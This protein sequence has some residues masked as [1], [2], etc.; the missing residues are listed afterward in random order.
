MC[1]IE[2]RVDEVWNPAYTAFSQ[3]SAAWLD[4]LTI[5]RT[6]SACWNNATNA[7]GELSAFWLK[8]I[9]LIYPFPFT[10][11]DVNVLLNWLNGNFPIRNG[12]CFNYIVGQEAI[13]CSPEYGV[14]NR[15]VSDS[16]GAGNQTV[17]FSWTCDCIGKGTYTG[18]ASKVVH[19]GFV[20]LNG[21][22]P[23]AYIN[24]FAGV[25]FV[26][27]SSYAWQGIGFIY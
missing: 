21:N 2:H 5:T 12:N 19:C 1:S 15:T 6:S 13:I 8:P 4:A 3:N 17:N 22:L 25:K 7:V 11:T 14:I 23:D 20:T 27:N 24:R 9:T 16:G 18:F 10:T 26:V